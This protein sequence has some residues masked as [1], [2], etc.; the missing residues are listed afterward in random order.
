MPFG[1]TTF[2]AALAVPVDVIRERRPDGTEVNYF[3]A[4]DGTVNYV[5]PGEVVY[6]YIRPTYI[7]AIMRQQEYT[8]S[9]EL[10][11]ELGRYAQNNIELLDFS[12]SMTDDEPC[13]EEELRDFLG[14]KE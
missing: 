11:W 14:Y 8:S 3:Y 2:D 7:D 6:R 13:S 10:L 12:F 1:E 4:E 9:G 5:P